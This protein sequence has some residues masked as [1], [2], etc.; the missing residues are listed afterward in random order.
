MGS[1][2]ISVSIPQDQWEFV[3]GMGISPSK[4]LQ[5]KISEIQDTK[6]KVRFTSKIKEVEDGEV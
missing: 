1:K 2:I 6:T 5:Q 3:S 4:I